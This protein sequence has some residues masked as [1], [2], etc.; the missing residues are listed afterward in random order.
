VLSLCS[1][2]TVEQDDPGHFRRSLTRCG[3]D[4]R[5]G[6]QSQQSSKINQR[7]VIVAGNNQV[8]VSSS[9]SRQKARSSMKRS[10]PEANSSDTREYLGP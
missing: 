9:R 6:M 4:V 3:T 7:I 10:R 5:W 2:M 8:K 1:V